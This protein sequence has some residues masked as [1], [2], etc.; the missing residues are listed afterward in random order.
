MSLTSRLHGPRVLLTVA[1]KSEV[2][3]VDGTILGDSYSIGLHSKT[4]S[5]RKP[6]F[7]RYMVSK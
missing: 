7:S 5:E 3:A 2:R 1:L 4:E 6:S